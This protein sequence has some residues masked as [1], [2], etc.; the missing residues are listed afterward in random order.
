VRRA[1]ALLLSK[2]SL[3]VG[4]RV[5]TFDAIPREASICSETHFHGPTP[6][7]GVYKACCWR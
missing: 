6:G 5:D 3:P 2:D 1:D 4:K 7:L